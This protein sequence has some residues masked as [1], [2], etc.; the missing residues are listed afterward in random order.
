MQGRIATILRKHTNYEG[1]P[2]VV[3]TTNQQTTLEE[4]DAITSIST[5]HIARGS[6]G[7]PDRTKVDGWGVVSIEEL[8]AQGCH[9]KRS[10]E[11]TLAVLVPLNHS[12][13]RM[14]VG[15]LLF[16]SCD[17]APEQRA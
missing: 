11:D 17:Q 16:H 13:A 5:K 14:G 8:E 9:L 1:S 10:P 4:I 2:V 15:D 12:L 6:D 3:L 7:R